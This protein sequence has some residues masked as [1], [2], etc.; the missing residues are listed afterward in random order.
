MLMIRKLLIILTTR[1]SVFVP[2]ADSLALFRTTHEKREGIIG[3]H[4]TQRTMECNSAA[5]TLHNKE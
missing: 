3:I 4:D 5:E 2:E 1:S